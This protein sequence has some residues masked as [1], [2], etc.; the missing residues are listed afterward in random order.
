MKHVITALGVSACLLVSSAGVVLAADPHTVTGTTGQPGAA[1][2]L[3]CGSVVD[4]VTLVAPKGSVNGNSSPFSPDP[5]KSINYAG[6]PGNPTAPGGV[7]NPAHS[8][9][10]Y[11][12]ACFQAT[13]KQIP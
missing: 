13:Q 7:G 5:T 1:N 2:G 12:V 11:D 4:G 3:T 9:S 10:E 8:I 6:N